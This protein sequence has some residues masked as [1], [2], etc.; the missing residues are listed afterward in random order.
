LEAY[1]LKKELKGMREGKTGNLQEIKHQTETNTKD[2]DG[3]GGGR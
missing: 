2:D 1:F 3:K